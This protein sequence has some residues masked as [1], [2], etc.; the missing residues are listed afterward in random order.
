MEPNI[1]RDIDRTRESWPIIDLPVEAGVENRRV[2]HGV[3][4]SGPVL[5]QINPLGIF[6]VIGDPKL[7]T[8]K[9]AAR[10][11]CDVHIDNP[12]A[13]LEVFQSRRATIEQKG[14]AA[15]IFC[16]FGLSFQLPTWRIHRNR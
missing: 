11:R 6:A 15:L 16:C 4:I 7:N 3:W 9:A 2:L 5:T 10:G 14:L 1:F 8:E 12:V 13:K